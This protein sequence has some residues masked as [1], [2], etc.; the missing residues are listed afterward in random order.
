MK[1]INSMWMLPFQDVLSPL[2]K[3][4]CQ[5][6]LPDLHS[7]VLTKAL[8]KYFADA[9]PVG[10][11]IIAGNGTFHRQRYWPRLPK[12]LQ[13][14]RYYVSFPCLCA[15][16]KC[17]QA[18]VEKPSIM[19]SAILV[20]TPI[21]LTTKPG[22]DLDS[23]STTS[24]HASSWKPEDTDVGIPPV[25]AIWKMHLHNADNGWRLRL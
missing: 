5:S 24:Q 16:Q 21:C 12:E 18:S 23:L 10:K 4:R 14:Q 19:I 8:P 22:A 7:I 2:G 25:P 20:T 17:T 1:R 9:E 13:H 15:A 3:G 6:S 11:L